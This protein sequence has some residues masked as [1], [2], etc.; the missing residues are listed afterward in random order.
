MTGRIVQ[1]DP[2][3]ADELFM[4][5]CGTLGLAAWRCKENGTVLR[6]PE[7]PGAI[8]TWFASPW[9]RPSEAASLSS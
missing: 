6:E 9:L 7:E 8:R 3:P 2:R 5:R 1:D 4:A